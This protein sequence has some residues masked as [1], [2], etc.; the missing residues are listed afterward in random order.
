MARLG[1]CGRRH[2][3]AFGRTLAR[4]SSR[5]AVTALL[6][7]DP[8]GAGA[9]CTR[10]S[11]LGAVPAEVGRHDQAGAG[12]PAGGAGWFGRRAGRDGCRVARGAVRRQP[13]PRGCTEGVARC[14]PRYAGRSDALVPARHKRPVCLRRSG[15]RIGDPS[16]GPGAAGR[17]GCLPAPA[18]ARLDGRAEQPAGEQCDGG[19]CRPEADRSRV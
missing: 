10:S 19:A 5:F 14:R 15:P 4:P 6:H 13:H 1:R 3:P 16:R 12:R 9:P 7:R 2:R 8:C 18:D 11:G 17:D